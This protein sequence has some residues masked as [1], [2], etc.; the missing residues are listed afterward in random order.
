MMRGRKRG[1]I[2]VGVLWCLALLSVIVVSLLHT[3]RLD[4]TLARH[5][6]DDIQ[7]RYLALAGIEK[8]KALLALDTRERRRAGR[9]YSAELADAPQHFRDVTLGRG[10]FNVLR[11]GDGAEGGGWIYGVSDEEG[12]LN[13]N[14]AE[15]N[16]LARLLG[17]TPDIVAAI[18]DWRDE[19]NAVSP[20]GAEADYYASLRPPRMP[21]NGPLQT[22]RELLMIRG[23]TEERLSGRSR[24]PNERQMSNGAETPGAREPGWDDLLTVS[25]AVRNVN[26]FGRDRVNVQSADERTL[27][28][29]SGITEEIA[30]AIVAGRG[31]N[32]FQTIADLLDITPAVPPG[33]IGPNG[34]PLT[35]GNADANASASGTPVINDDLFQ[36]IA[37]DVTVDDN[38]EM[39]GPINI[40]SATVDVLACLPPVNRTLAQAIIGRRRS[41]G[42][43]PN[44][45]ALLKVPGMT[46]GI[47]KQILP[48]ITA[49]SETYRILAEGVLADRGLKRRIEVVVRLGSEGFTTVS[50]REDDL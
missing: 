3:A 37:D 9:S 12:R 50:Y 47:F 49:R 33:A 44:V 30:R 4:L 16:E 41:I 39:N 8:A 48:R 24:P 38:S 5:R 2:L 17:M 14:V 20:G 45:A 46:R 43:F 23:V 10:R 15:T 6:G 1:S 25:S 31:R 11:R 13:V 34:L 21:R 7:A 26:A 42:F 18:V 19:D 40:N 28:S 29:V 32:R 35:S 22:I 27:T 36:S